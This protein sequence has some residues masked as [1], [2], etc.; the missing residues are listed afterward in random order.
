MSMLRFL[1]GARSQPKKR[2]QTSEEKAAQSK[3][4]ESKC[5]KRQIKSHWTRDYPWL[6]IK[7]NDDGKEIMYCSFCINAKIPGD[8]SAFIKGCANLKLETIKKHEGSNNHYAATKHENE[9]E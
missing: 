8:K 6:R 2:K 7:T 5:Q 3:E 1:T 4:Y 9:K